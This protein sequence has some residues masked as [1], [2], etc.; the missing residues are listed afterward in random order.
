MRHRITHGPLTATLREC[1]L[2]AGNRRLSAQFPAWTD[3]PTIHAIV[4][5]SVSVEAAHRR[6]G[7][8]KRF[9]AMVCADPRWEMVVV[10]GV[11]NLHLAAYL[12]REGW[13]VDVGV[14][15]FYRRKATG[16]NSGKNLVDGEAVEG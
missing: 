10:E 8:L 3:R 12:E 5:E 1:W 7:H 6:Q 2:D 13:E 16:E 11:G 9:L 15:D 14:G 4:I